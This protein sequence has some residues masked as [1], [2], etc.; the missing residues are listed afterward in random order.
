[1]KMNDMFFDKIFC[2]NCNDPLDKDL[3]DLRFIV[4]Q[5]TTKDKRWGK[6]RPSRWLLLEDKIMEKKAAG[7]RIMKLDDVLRLNETSAYPLPKQS[8]IITFLKQLHEL[9]T[10]MH[11]KDDGLRNLVI[12]DPQWLIDSL[13]II[14]TAECFWLRDYK[15]ELKKL[16]DTGIIP[17]HVIEQIW[18]KKGT[19]RFYEFREQLMVLM[20]KLDLISNPKMY[21]DTGKQITSPDVVVPCMLSSAPNGFLQEYRK[22]TKSKNIPLVF[23]FHDDF[24]PSAIVYRL[25]AACNMHYEMKA[26]S[27]TI[28]IF[29][30][31]AVFKMRDNHFLILE[32]RGCNIIADVLSFGKGITDVGICQGVREFLDNTLKCIIAPHKTF[33]KYT[34][35]VSCGKGVEFGE[36]ALV[37]W[38]SILEHKQDEQEQCHGHR[39]KPPHDVHFH[40]IKE[41]WLVKV[42]KSHKKSHK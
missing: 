1:M 34:L 25:L 27:E 16:K 13:K 33:M 2:I 14:I 17:R 23:S 8:E 20:S 31:A 15:N 19:E 41:H 11:Y 38:D 24:L 3:Q 21:D 6:N 28:T 32:Y 10:I 9:G 30:D 18:E 39:P 40:D 22:E 36:Y 7:E 12:L 29:C 5:L 35:H 42:S 37:K 4:L 26:E